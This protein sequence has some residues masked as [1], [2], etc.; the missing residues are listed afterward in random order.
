[1]VCLKSVCLNQE[2]WFACMYTRDKVRK[3]K[4]WHDGVVGLMRCTRRVML[5][6]CVESESIVIYF[7]FELGELMQFYRSFGGGREIV[8]SCLGFQG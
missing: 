4:V 8:E 2:A 6:Q 1:M 7:V 5:Y 3:A